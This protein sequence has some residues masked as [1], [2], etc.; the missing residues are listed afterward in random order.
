MVNQSYGT[1]VKEIKGR[2]SIS[3][4]IENYVSLKRSGKGFIGI[5]PFHEDKNPSFHIN[6]DKGIYHCF[7]CG[8]G[9]D[10]IGFL[11]RYKNVSFQE[12]LE[13]LA[14]R[15]EIKIEK[16]YSQSSKKSKYEILFRINSLVGEFYHRNLNA[17]ASGKAPKEYL[18]KRGFSI[19]TIGEFFL[20]Y[21]PG[22]WDNLVRFLSSKGISLEVAES[23]GL[24]IS[25]KNKDGYYD[26]FRNRIVF[27]IKDIEG[28]IVG[29]GGRVL[30]DIGT[31]PKY[32]NSPESEIYHKRSLFYGLDKSNSYI[33]RNEKAIIVEGY[34]DFIS[35]WS[36]GIKNVVA[37][38]GT[39]LT[40]E[41]ASLLK[42]H[43]DR[44]VVVFDGDKSGI[45]ASLRVLELFL[46]TGIFPLM[47]VLPQGYDPD[48]FIIREGGDRFLKLVENAT[49]LLDFFIKTVQNEFKEGSL[50]LS[51]AI[52]KIANLIS[53]IKDSI[54]RAHQIRRVAEGFGIRENEFY[55][56]VINE[57]Q[58]NS[59]TK[60]SF[61]KKFLAY[62][63]VLLKIIL[64]YP[65]LSSIIEREDIAEKLEDENIRTIIK[66]IIKGKISDLSTILLSF[67]DV[68]I[69]QTLS[70][71]IFHSEDVT[72]EGIARRMLNSCVRNIKIRRIDEDLK[73]LRFEIEQAVDNKDT[74]LEKKLIQ[75]YKNLLEQG[76]LVK[77]EIN[78]I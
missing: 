36:S 41:H 32:I 5:C 77:G 57:R 34:F 23:I 38:L 46:E 47:V 37:T 49:S 78:E 44:V 66:V 69:Q 42:R 10:I 60:M 56:L 75:D 65:N 45:N 67:N 2:L 7:G 3:S 70:E 26:R 58:N 29:F 39:S 61:D 52:R 64:K 27:P 20:G 54:E 6:E 13:E 35:L 4:L 8:A 48:S 28:R 12:A 31:E 73:I 18:V 16:R 19:D 1:L 51:T 43:T 30:E 24:V 76:K 14:R 40:N 71:A 63:K 11:M 55:S 50:N 15:A 17:G 9:G 22:A 62:E 59:E 21:A 74:L 68:S 33:R 72:D 53:M 25:R